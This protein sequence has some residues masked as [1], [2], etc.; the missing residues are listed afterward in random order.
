MVGETMIRMYQSHIREAEQLLAC[1]RVDDEKALEYLYQ[2]I[3]SI[4]QAINQLEQPR[5][6]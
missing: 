4:T 5:E 1:A 3:V 6:G 2:A